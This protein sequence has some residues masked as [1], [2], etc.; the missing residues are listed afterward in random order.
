MAP[1]DCVASMAT[2]APTERRALQ[3]P[4]ARASHPSVDV[5]NGDDGDALVDRF[6]QGPVQL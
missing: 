2:T 4:E 5:R 6:E 3:S 1:S